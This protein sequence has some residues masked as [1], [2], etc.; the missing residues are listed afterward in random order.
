MIVGSIGSLSFLSFFSVT[1]LFINIILC[2]VFFSFDHVFSY[3][4]R[5]TFYFETIYGGVMTLRSIDVRKLIFLYDFIKSM[6]RE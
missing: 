3:L 1:L 6:M 4:R 5:G 2:L